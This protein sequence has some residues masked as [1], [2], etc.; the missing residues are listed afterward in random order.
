MNTDELPPILEAK[1]SE[2]RRRVWIVK[3][4]EGLLAACFGIALSYV[5]VFVLDRFMETPAWLRGVLLAS[6]AA[7]LGFGVPLKW[8][9]WVWRQRRLE[10]AARLLRRKFPRLGD[11]LLGIVELAH[12][13][14]VSG[15]SETLVQAAMAQAAEAVKDQDFTRAVPDARHRSWAWAA[16]GAVALAIVAFVTVSDAARNAL[17]RWLTPWREVDRYTFAKVDQLPKNLVVPYA[18]PFSLPVKLSTDTKWSPERGTGRIKGQ[19]EI[20]VPLQDGSYPLA[21]PP[22]KND[23]PMKVSLGD[24][25]K[26]VQ[27]EPRTRPEL[28]TLTAR[29]RLPAY[30]QY[31]TEPGIEVRGGSIS[32]LKGSEVAFIASASRDLADAEMDGAK[33]KVEGDKLLTNFSKVEKSGE[34]HFNWRDTLGL[35]PR[36]SLVLKV[37]AV[38]DE[39]PRITAR[40]D[41]Q[42]TVVL[43]S[44]VLAFDLSI[45]DDFGVKRAGLEWVGEK[46]S[47]TD[48][49]PMRGEKVAVGGEPEKRELD[50]RAT[51]CATRESVAPQT[52]QVRAWAEDYLPGRKRAYSQSFIL[53][54]LNKQDH[55]LWLTEQFGKWLQVAR[56]SY[57]REQQLHQTNKELRELSAAELDRPENRRKVMQQASSEHANADRLDNI[58][59]L[60]KSLVEQATHNPEFE[61]KRLEAWADM[62]KNLRDIAGQRMPSVA[63]LLKQSSNA[64][65]KS[66]AGASP[67][68]PST[69]DQKPQPPSSQNPS[70]KPPTGDQK[71]QQSSSQDSSSKPPDGEQKSPGES[72]PSAPNVTTGEQT[73]STSAPKLPDPNAKP[74]SPVPSIADNEKSNFK[75]EDNKPD[76][77]PKPSPSGSGKLSLPQTSLG[78]APTNK[79]PDDEESPPESPAQDKIQ[80]AVAEQRDLLAE[81]AKVADQLNEI[82]AGLEASTFV[83]RLK[84]ASRTQMTVASD[85]NSKTLSAFGLERKDVTAEPATHV[86]AIAGREKDQSEV[87]R[88][89]QSDLEAFYQRRQ[90]EKFKNILEQMKKA[91]IVSAL[92]R[93][94]TQ[95]G[96]NLSGRSIASSE[97]W[98]D[99]LDRWAEELVSAAEASKSK[100][101][102][103]ADK[104]SLPPEI[105]LMVMQA[106]R[107][108][109]K[110]RD[111]TREME[112]ARPALTTSEYESKALPLA[113]KQETNAVLTQTASDAILMLPKGAED[114]KDELKLLTAVRQVMDEAGAI[115]ERPDTGS[116]AIAA[117]TEAIELLLQAKRQGKG[118]GGG[119]GGG[120]PGGGG[121]GTADGMSLAELGPGAD[122]PAQAVVRPVGQ[123]TG[124][125]GREFPEEFKNGLDAY[126]NKLEGQGRTKP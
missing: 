68:K 116:E 105:I 40:R 97:F 99:T 122:S 71:S 5:L 76:E 10:D 43:D 18:E 119:G 15:R 20:N 96:V 73:P 37:Q 55:A 4:A 94:S 48:E 64:A 121:S 30:L 62:L 32:V 81:F 114:F 126:F 92:V 67:G 3:L 34:R 90:D 120:N 85:L 7:V 38:D 111:E 123:Q 29:L 41:S 75:P 53:H 47:S 58:T 50:A 9:R 35:A 42:E 101:G 104:P 26:T 95:A 77:K 23:A 72:K 16:G 8:H 65:T 28:A 109:M 25:R 57:E 118:G 51:F 6:G 125:A 98:A 66:M 24:V 52:L 59:Q 108:E 80:K 46:K 12:K 87:V 113:R 124:R 19:P 39:A 70:G 54:I 115:L 17:A 36:E 117:E 69:G 78:A 21:F 100:P 2:F 83:K 60:G 89:I 93:T 14:N 45:A 82:M 84:F 63:D 27:V 11:Q 74:T 102:K 79:K 56:E 44:E 88:V 112:N 33:Q 91:E 31:K 103:G 1:L 61:A 22:Q 110:L 86:D 107:D 13:D 106:L 49:N